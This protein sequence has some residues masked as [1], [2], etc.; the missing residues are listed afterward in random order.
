MPICENT[1]P[2]TSRLH[3]LSKLI[4]RE[5]NA[6]YQAE[7]GITHSEARILAATEGSSAALSVVEL[8]RA[9]N[10][11]KSQASRM[12]ARLVERGL[13]CRTSDSQDERLAQHSLTASGRAL[14]RRITRI[15][16]E[17]DNMLVATLTPRERMALER[18]I[19]KVADATV[20]TF[21]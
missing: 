2:L 11:D 10:I 16:H 12:A 19:G 18:A 8:A 4:E 14:H 17:F 3:Q 15:A 21:G 20:T 5:A 6:R 1:P 9:A 13:M 7:L